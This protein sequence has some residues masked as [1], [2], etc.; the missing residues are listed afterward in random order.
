MI[1]VAAAEFFS[2]KGTVIAAGMLNTPKVV[3][4]LLHFD[5]PQ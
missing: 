4:M 1:L 3:K 5:L 2:R